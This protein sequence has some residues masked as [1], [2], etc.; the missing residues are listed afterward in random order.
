M[1]FLDSLGLVDRAAYLIVF[2][3]KDRFFLGP[4]GQN[5]LHGLA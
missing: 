2:A 5:H 3:L 1:Q 4:H